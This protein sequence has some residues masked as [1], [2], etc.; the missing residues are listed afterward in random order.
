MASQTYN[1]GE[2]PHSAR[3]S[4][5]APRPKALVTGASSGLGAA[6]ARQLAS[7]GYDL[8]L[9]AR[10]AQRL[11]RLADEIAQDY[12]SS[13]MILPADLSVPEETLRVAES[14]AEKPDLDTLV[15]AAGFGID[16]T[17]ADSD[18]KAQVDMVR[19]HLEANLRL[20]HAAL[21]PMLARGAGNI[22]GVSSMGA[23]APLPGFSVYAATKSALVAFYESLALELDGTSVCV[24]V[25]CPG[26]TRTEFQEREGTDFTTVPSFL[27]MTPER[28]VRASLKQLGGRRPVCV[29]GFGNRVISWLCGPFGRPV[30]R[31][32][33]KRYGWREAG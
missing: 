29:P 33:A 22:I 9:V 5:G 15:N 10:R 14:I 19:V 12:G 17:F 3:T 27:W 26:F 6:Y 4:S 11:E 25:L 32:V 1:S 30:Q 20:T 18:I 23:F 7:Q 8:I 31:I 16:G 13:A 21:G 24:Q 28:V 2:D